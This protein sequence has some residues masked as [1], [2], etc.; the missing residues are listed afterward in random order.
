MM[1]NGVVHIIDV[2]LPS[3]VTNS[4]AGRESLV[5]VT[6]KHSRPVVLAGLD[7]ALLLLAS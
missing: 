3:W 6:C 1:F 4:I 2:L 5:L 7:T